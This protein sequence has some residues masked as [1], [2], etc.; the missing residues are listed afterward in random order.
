[1]VRSAFRVLASAAV[2]SWIGTGALVAQA[3]GPHGGPNPVHVDNG[4]HGS[5][6]RGSSL[7]ISQRIDRNPQLASRLQALV[8]AGM[9]LD[10]AAAGFK[11]QGQFIAALHVAHNLG[12]SF[13]DL[14][15][16]M[17]GP[18]H[19]S[20]GKAIHALKPTADASAE[21]KKADTEAD[22]DLK[23]SKSDTNKS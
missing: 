15:A 19:D 3:G 12:I 4:N 11:N 7:T 2:V 17:T 1:M 5:P 21:V 22:T 14:K 6:D 8:P 10:Q 20:L 23:V 9:T 16:D 18:N 13:V